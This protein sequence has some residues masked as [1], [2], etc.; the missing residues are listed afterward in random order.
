MFRGEYKLSLD[1]K[2]RLSIPSHYRPLIR[3]QAKGA[4][5]LTQCPLDRCLW[6]YPLPEWELIEQK[7][8]ALSDFIPQ[9][10]RVKQM[11]YAYANDCPCDNNYRIL[12]PPALREYANI[13]KKIALLGQGRRLEI[14]NEVAWSP[15]SREWR[16]EEMENPSE[17]LQ[18]LSL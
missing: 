15:R 4:L 5:I 3:Q 18:S 16:R 9:Q 11:M 13:D 17:A 6:L 10:R 2:G 7:L 12:I 8:N 14:W 1:T